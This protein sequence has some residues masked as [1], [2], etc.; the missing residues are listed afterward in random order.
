MIEVDIEPPAVALGVVDRDVRGPETVAPD[1]EHGFGH[2]VAHLREVDRRSEPP[3]AYLPGK[4]G[5]AALALHDELGR[6]NPLGRRNDPRKHRV[7][8]PHIE[9]VDVHAGVIAHP[10]G[11]EV[12]P[13]E[14]IVLGPVE[15]R[16]AGAAAGEVP[17]RNQ[18]QRRPGDVVDL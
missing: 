13:H 16:H 14:R 4:F 12:P 10:V 11:G 5:L 3:G 1:V 17:A 6:R 18:P 15:H 8:Q 7:E 2:A 9:T